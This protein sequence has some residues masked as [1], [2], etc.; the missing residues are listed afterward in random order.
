MQTPR[1]QYL[2]ALKFHLGNLIHGY[3][4]PQCGRVPLSIIRLYYRIAKDRAAARYPSGAS[5]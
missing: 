3:G 4:P 5:I 2:S 1:A